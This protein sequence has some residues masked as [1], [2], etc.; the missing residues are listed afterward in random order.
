MCS[1]VETPPLRRNLREGVAMFIRSKGKPAKWSVPKEG[2]WGWNDHYAIPK[3]APNATGAY[4]FI[5]TMIS[6]ASNAS[7]SNF[8]VSGTP[9]TKSIKLLSKQSRALFDYSN[10]EASL[11]SLGF[12]SLPPLSREGKVMSY[13]DWNRAWARVK[14]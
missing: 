2:T 4:A 14:G 3:K 6:P 13:S 8:T 11:K 1:R 9:V 7:I 5:N 10:V 12:Y